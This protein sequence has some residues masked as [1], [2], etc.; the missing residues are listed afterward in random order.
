MDDVGF[1]VK[2]RDASQMIADACEEYLEKHAPTDKRAKAKDFD[3]LPW[4]DRE[5][6]KGPFQ[7]TS[8]NATNNG[9]VFQA[10]QAFV[11]DHDGF[12]QLAGYIY[13]F[14]NKNPNVID[15]RKKLR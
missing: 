7:R 15:R 4:E 13:W 11:K 5:G 6:A 2:L 8:K 12:C 9:E 3:K 1:V 14:D 10:L